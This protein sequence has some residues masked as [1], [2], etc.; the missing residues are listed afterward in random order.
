MSIVHLSPERERE[1]ERERESGFMCLCV[2]GGR[3]QRTLLC[4]YVRQ[5]T[6]S[7]LESLD[8]DDVDE[9]WTLSTIMF[10][11]LEKIALLWLFFISKMCELFELFVFFYWFLLI[12]NLFLYF[13]QQNMLFLKLL[14]IFYRFSLISTL[15]LY[16]Y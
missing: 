2:R 11:F 15:F 1:R 6:F 14:I 16:F 3:N 5:E 9:C 13:Y 7:P 12:S 10:D 8:Y 4:V